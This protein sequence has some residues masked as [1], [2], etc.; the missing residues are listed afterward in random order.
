MAI[1]HKD[2]VTE[3]IKAHGADKVLF[4]TDY[5]MWSHEE[6]LERFYS[7]GLT[8]EERELILWKNAAKLLGIV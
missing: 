3:M 8:D 7:L 5:P 4:G 1:L 6:E 2:K